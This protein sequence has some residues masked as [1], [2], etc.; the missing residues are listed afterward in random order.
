MIFAGRA[1]T[2]ARRPRANSEP[3]RPIGTIRGVA[4]GAHTASAGSRSPRAGVSS[5]GQLREADWPAPCQVAASWPS[6]VGQST[7]RM[8]NRGPPRFSSRAAAGCAGRRP[9]S[10][11][12][13]WRVRPFAS[14][15][16]RTDPPRSSRRPPFHWHPVNDGRLQFLPRMKAKKAAKRFRNLHQLSGHARVMLPC[17]RINLSRQ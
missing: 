11:G 9:A 1:P 17:S 14:F 13:A 6:D 2:R 15:A 5:P 3:A 16:R 8:P 12:D 10:L 4:T 7:F